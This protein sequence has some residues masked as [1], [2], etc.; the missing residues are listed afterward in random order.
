MGLT[1]PDVAASGEFYG[2]L[3][4]PA[5]HKEAEPPLR[6]YVTLGVGYLALGSVVIGTGEESADGAPPRTAYVDHFCAL[7]DGYNPQA[8]RTELEAA[9]IELGGGFG[10]V[11]DPDGVRL[12]LLGVPGGMAR[13]TV[14]ADPIATDPPAVHP[15]GLDHVMVRVSDMAR[16]VAHYRVFFGPEASRSADPAQAWFRVAGTWLGLEQAGTGES[17]AVS[18]FCLNVSAFDRDAV[19]R[20]LRTLGA[21]ILPEGAESL[22]TRYREQP[23]LRFRDPD[24]LIVE[25]KGRVA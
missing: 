1:V 10:M 24:G 11:A 9:G 21:E 6:Y 18:H 8:F 2:R 20:T 22:R 12:Q 15:L 17:P 25:L 16:S 19:S 3:L 23:R 7:A 13:T 14:P 4:N 5:L